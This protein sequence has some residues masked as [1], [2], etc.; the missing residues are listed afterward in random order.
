MRENR[1][2]ALP[3]FSAL[4]GSLM[5]RPET[6]ST[7][8][9]LL[10]GVAWLIV[11]ALCGW[12]LHMAP[13]S[14]VGYDLYGYLPLLWH[15]VVNVALGTTFVVPFIIAAAF[16]NR[17]VSVAEAFA[18]ML[19]AHWPAVLLLLPAAFVDPVKYSMLN[20]DLVAAFGANA[21]MAISFAVLL[22]VVVVWMVRWCYI[23]F[24][25]VV[26]RGGA[27]VLMAFGAALCISALATSKILEVLYRALLNGWIWS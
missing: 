3:S 2:V 15:I 17:K 6:N 7:K 9:A 18:R 19:F 11:S 5:R 8:N 10:W 20:N 26:Q 23:A 14:A 22:V 24:R 16:V 12:H 27:E 13:V 4:L 25:K 1:G 21:A